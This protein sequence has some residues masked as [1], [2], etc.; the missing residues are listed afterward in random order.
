MKD[1]GCCEEGVVWEGTCMLQIPLW[2]GICGIL[3][4][5]ICVAKSNFFFHRMGVQKVTPIPDIC[6]LCSTGTIVTGC[7]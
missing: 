2:E 1:P 5:G 6:H 4:E 7:Q 3:W